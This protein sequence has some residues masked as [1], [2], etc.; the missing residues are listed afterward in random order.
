MLCVVVCDCVLCVVVYEMEY[1]VV[2]CDWVLYV[3]VQVMKMMG[4]SRLVHW[5][6][7]FIT[8]GVILSISVLAMTAIL[9]AFGVLI[10]TNFFIVWAFL[11]LY[12]VVVILF[13]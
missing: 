13:W 5:L 3:V 10:H 9:Y 1:C 6:S 12:A 2:V 4:L 8:S 7:W 11:E